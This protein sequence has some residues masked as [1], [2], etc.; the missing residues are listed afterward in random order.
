MV[1]RVLKGPRVFKGGGNWGTLRIPF[2]KI[3]EPQEA[4]GNIRET[5]PLGTPSLNN[6]I[7]NGR[8]LYASKIRLLGFLA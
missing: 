7:I 2:G 8:R 6:P 4:L 3:G 5:P 1:C